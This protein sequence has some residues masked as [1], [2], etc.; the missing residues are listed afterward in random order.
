MSCDVLELRQPVWIAR[1]AVA[2]VPNRQIILA[3]LASARDGNR[4]GMRI[5]AVFNQLRDSLKRIAL[6]QCNDTEGIPI[7]PDPQLTAL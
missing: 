2:I 3:V 5:D 7:I 1:D 6:R 4:L